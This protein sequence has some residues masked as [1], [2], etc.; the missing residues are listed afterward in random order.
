[1][2]AQQF[3]HPNQQKQEVETRKER[4]ATLNVFVSERHGWLTS[5]PGAPEVTLECLPES[6]V[7]DELC[8]LGY[9]VRPAGQ[10]QRLLAAA[11]TERFTTNAKG[12]F[13]PLTEGS[14]RQTA[15]TV[16]HA[17]FVEVRRY[18]FAIR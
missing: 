4:F 18:S 6:A 1:M 9:D 7:P 12:E 16:T 8:R 10:G 5:I 11:I 17:G 13:E 3:H 2:T 14:S 15:S